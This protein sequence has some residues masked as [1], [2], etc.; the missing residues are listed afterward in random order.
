MSEKLPITPI[1]AS[2]LVA[3]PEGA[4]VASEKIAEYKTMVDDFLDTNGIERDDVVFAGIDDDKLVEPSSEHGNGH[5]FGDYSS[6]LYPEAH[7]DFEAGERW[8]VN[9]IKYAAEHRT[10]AIYSK[11]SLDDNI[12]NKKLTDE[13]DQKFGTTY[14]EC[15]PDVLEQSLIGKIH[16]PKAVDIIPTTDIS[17]VFDTEEIITEDIE[18]VESLTPK[19][20]DEI[21]DFADA[22]HE[23]RIDNTGVERRLQELQ[24]QEDKKIKGASELKAATL[25]S[26]CFVK[27]T[28]A[29]QA[30]LQGFSEMYNPGDQQT[31]F[32]ADS[33]S[34]LMQAV[35]SGDEHRLGQVS[36]EIVDQ[37]Q[38][39][40]LSR[41]AEFDPH[42]V[43]EAFIVGAV[44]ASN[45]NFRS[46]RLLEST[47]GNPNRVKFREKS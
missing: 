1:E 15:E 33:V 46:E 40:L 27:N 35:A 28:G 42:G 14:I 32:A 36:H 24:L 13:S 29:P 25:G 34:A 18:L 22:V 8:Q 6:L 43:V 9:P 2:T 41:G 26:S 3:H 17:A 4:V 31:R 30:M 10:L 23:G 37:L 12:F 45:K 19:Q 11:K 47:I 7:D 16:L 20:L 44:A 38:R 39:T 5:F 21:A